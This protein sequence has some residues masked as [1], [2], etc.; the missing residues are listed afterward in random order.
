MGEHQGGHTDGDRS[1]A[2]AR[3]GAGIAVAVA[4]ALVVGGLLASVT[5]L[6]RR[7]AAEG[8]PAGPVELVMDWDALTEAAARWDVAPDEALGRL[9]SE[10][11]TTLALTEFSAA[12]LAARGRALLLSSEQLRALAQWLSA[13]AGRGAVTDDGTWLL[14]ASAPPRRIPAPL[15]QAGEYRVGF[16]REGWEAA[17]KAGVAVMLRYGAGPRLMDQAAP[18]QGEAGKGGAG[19]GAAEDAGY[20]VAAGVPVSRV[21]IFAGDKLPELEEAA[22]L[23]RRHGAAAGMVEFSRLDPLRA[24]S[25]QFGVAVAAVHSARAEEL[26]AL[27]PQAA[28]ERYLR[29]VR[30]RSV[31]VLYLRPLGSLQETAEMVAR[32]RDGLRRQ[33]YAIGLFAP[34]PAFTGPGAVQAALMAGALPG[35]ALAGWLAWLRARA[36]RLEGAGVLRAAAAALALAALSGAVVAAAGRGGWDHPLYT[37]SRQAV[38]LAAALVGPPAALGAALAAA[39]AAPAGRE[40]AAGP[41]AP[42]WRVFVAAAAYV[43]ASL[44]A[45]LLVGGMLS[46]DQFMLRLELFRGVKA[47]HAAPLVASAVLAL[48]AAQGSLAQW[49]SGVEAPI[50]WR[51]AALALAALAAVAYYLARTGNELA[52]VSAGERWLRGWL[53]GALEVRPR[54]K[55]FLVGYPALALALFLWRGGAASGRPWLFSAVSAAASVAAISVINSWAHVHTPVAVTLAR[56]GNGLA[57]GAVTAIVAWA[58]AAAWLR[59]DRRAATA[60]EGGASPASRPVGVLRL[61]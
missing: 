10:G 4:A 14:M 15:P 31:R 57:V 29:A 38:A 44:A 59:P 9:A 6:L 52:P 22:W 45:G 2:A 8:P 17:R 16:P 11:V 1:G 30:E 7:A 23:L 32:I 13:P 28:A 55:E 49:R 35:L 43:G 20:G 40:G 61:R 39:G 3:L 24:L 5:V 60:T 46:D 58:A 19:E 42:P 56:V 37:L 12:E 18:G 34:R 48:W 47:A 54:S 51:D 41:A 27:G 36:V 53:E 25:R 21:S 50:R 26:Q 33:G